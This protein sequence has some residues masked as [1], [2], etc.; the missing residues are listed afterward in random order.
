MVG[1]DCHMPLLHRSK[2]YIWIE[3]R[4]QRINEFYFGYMI[5][6]NLF[7]N[8]AF[9]DQVK[10]CFKHTFGPDTISHINKI[11]QKKIMHKMMNILTICQ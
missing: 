1:A 8:R 7:N 9:K 6:P 3:E 10:L 2:S 5:N 4:N 11:L